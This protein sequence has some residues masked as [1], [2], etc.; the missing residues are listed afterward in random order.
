[1]ARECGPNN[2]FATISNTIVIAR[3]VRATHGSPASD[4]KTAMGGPDNPGHDGVRLEMNPTGWPAFA[5]HDT[6][7][8]GEVDFYTA[9]FIRSRTRD[10]GRVIVTRVPSPGVLSRL[11]R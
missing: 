1:M 4:E 5:G 8:G 11:T 10:L 9:C 6:V 2:V 3:L 7:A